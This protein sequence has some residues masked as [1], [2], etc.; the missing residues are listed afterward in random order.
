MDPGTMV[1]A[2]RGAGFRGASPAT[3]PGWQIESVSRSSTR[4]VDRG[5]RVTM[6]PTSDA[7]GSDRIG[8]LTGAEW[9]ESPRTGPGPL[10]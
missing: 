5:A 7:A 4:T 2:G 6:R 1:C 3:V 10:S 8:R 9:Y